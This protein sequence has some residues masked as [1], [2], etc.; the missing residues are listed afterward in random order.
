M[1]ITNTMTQIH[2]AIKHYSKNYINVHDIV[3][4]MLLVKR[5]VYETN[6]RYYFS[7]Y[8]LCLAVKNH[9]FFLREKAPSLD[10]DQK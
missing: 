10:S 8:L 9:R 2:V 6:K 5:I 7:H 3:F 4:Q 1:L